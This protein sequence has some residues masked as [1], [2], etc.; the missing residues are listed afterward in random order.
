MKQLFFIFICLLLP[1]QFSFS[2]YSGRVFT[3]HNSSGSF[4]KGDTPL[5]SIVVTDG[6]NTV[7]TGKDGR[8]TLPG[9][10]KTRF[11]TITTPAGYEI[12]KHY[13]P[14][15]NSIKSYDFVLIPS[16]RTKQSDHS[17]LQITDTEIHTRGVASNWVGYLKNYIHSE[18]AAFLIHTGDICYES[19]L[20]N[21]IQVVNSQTM[22]CP[23]YYCIGNHDLVKG[24]YGEQLF[25]SIYGPCWYSFD[26]GNVHYVVTPMAGG[27]HSPSYTKKEIYQWLKNDLA[28][29]P[30]GKQLVIFNHDILTT[31]DHFHFG[32]SDTE[33]VDLRQY[34]LKAWIYGHWHINYV[35]NQNGIYTTCTAPLD[36][37]GIDHSPSAFRVIRMQ[38]DTIE[39]ISL[40]YCFVDHQTVIASPIDG[41]TAALLPGQ[42]IPLSVNTYDSGCEI[43][44]VTYSLKEKDHFGTPQ[45]MTR[46]S[47]WNWYAEAHPASLPSETTTMEIQVTAEFNDGH[48]S[49]AQ[50]RFRYNPSLKTKIETGEAWTNLLKNPA[51]TGDSS[52][53]LDLPLQLAWVKNVGG[54]I[55]MTSPLIAEHRVFVASIDDNS[56]KNQGVFALDDQTGKI[57]WKYPTRNSIKNSIAYDNQTVFAQDANSWLYAID[58]VSGKLKWEKQ[59]DPASPP[60]LEEGLIAGNGIVYAGTGTGLGA[61]HAEDGR[62]LWVNTAWKKHEAATTTLTLGNNILTAGAQWKALYGN[63]SRT[64]EMLWKLTK[65]GLSD[66]GASTTLHNGRFY[67]ISR[68]SLFIIEPQTGEIIS[69]KQLTEFNLNVTSTPLITDSEI[70]FGTADKGIIALNKEDLSIKWNTPVRLSLVYTPPYVTVPSASIESSPILSNGIVYFGASDGYLY[71]IK[72]GTGEP[73]WE[74]QTGAPVF[75]SMAISGNLLIAVDFSGNVYAFTGKDLIHRNFNQE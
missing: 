45:N 37:G 47:D 35:R 2:T 68:N 62:P 56:S 20:K 26:V 30:P 39:K 28:M 43:K 42:S 9:Y 27:D 11:I 40:H 15:N 65:D 61:Y 24:E 46:K 59:L 34:N 58:A 13:I 32:I 75:A 53:S 57:I 60:Y 3:D 14:V 5:S 1:V 12:D 51:H 10:E 29:M 64:G 22:N 73:V 63:D 48:I 72:A 8:F 38:K 16:Q 41:Q 4:D 6:Q 50:S 71:G 25:E 18:N 17:F 69:Q 31:S 23:V 7:K 36:K 67:V 54:N 70:I 49:I 66:R 74:M 33:Q 52:G 19:G 44:Q 55:F 21:H